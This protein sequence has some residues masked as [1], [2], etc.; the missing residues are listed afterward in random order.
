MKNLYQFKNPCFK[1]II[2]DI[3]PVFSPIS[4][5][6]F[7]NKRHFLSL[8]AG[9]EVFTFVSHSSIQLTLLSMTN[10][11]KSFPLRPLAA[12]LTGI[13]SL[14][15]G[16]VGSLDLRAQGWEVYF[17]G[18]KEDFGHALVQAQ[19]RGFAIA[20]FSESFGADGDMDVY[21]VRTDVDG[22]EIWSQVY[23]EGFV[24]HGY[25][26][27][28]T[29]DKGFLVVGDIRQSPLTEPNVYLLKID[30]HGQK[31]WSKQYG[32]AGNEVGFRVIQVVQGGGYLI[33]GS[34]VAPGG[35]PA[36]VLALRV[37]ESGNQAW[38]FTYGGSGADFGRGAVEMPDGFLL[39][40]TAVNP[41]NGTP[42]VYLLKIGLDGQQVWE[43]HFGSSDDIDEGYDLV[44]TQDG[45]LVIAGYTQSLSDVLLL[46][47]NPDGDLLWLKA[48]GGPLGDQA[49]DLLENSDGELVLTGITEIDVTNSDAFLAKYDVNGDELWTQTIGRGSHVDLGQALV[50][51]SDGGYVVAGYNSLFGTF[52]NDL[53]LIKAGPNGSVY[54]NH[55]QGKVFI[56][57]GDC[58]LQNGEAG[59][60]SWIVRASSASKTFFG[61]TD[62]DGNFD[63]TVDTGSYTM[64][65][66][67]R[68]GLWSACIA[69]Y[70]IAL[71]EQYDTLVR[72][73]PIL[74]NY[75]CPL[76][77][78]DVSTAVVQN[79]SN[80]GYVVSYCNA[81]TAGAIDPEVHLVLDPS[82]TFTGA[83]LPLA[84]QDDSLLVFEIPDLAVGECGEFSFTAASDCAGL[85]GEAYAVDAHIYP[86]SICLP[87]SP[88]WDFSSVKV[89]GY[90]SA[91]TVVFTIR[92]EGQGDMSAPLDFIV[93]EDQILGLQGAFILN[94]GKDTTI[95]IASAEGKTLRLLAEQ[96]PGHPGE[97]YPTV[98]IEG[99]TTSGAFS[100][101]FV[102]QF[103]EDEGDPFSAVDVQESN[104]D[105]PLSVVLRA[106]PKG[107]LQQGQQLIPANTDIGYH[108]YFRNTGTDTLGR[109]VIR[110][111]VSSLLDIATVVAGAGSHD[112]LMEVYSFGV[113]KFTFEALNLAPDQVGFVKFRISQKP[114]NPQG[115]EIRNSAAAF[116]GY[117]APL[118]TEPYVHVVGG[119]TLTDFLAITGLTQPE[120]A[121]VRVVAYPNPFATAIDFE[122]GGQPSGV[123]ALELYDLRGALLRRE[124][125]VGD[126]LRLW[127]GDLSPGMYVYR[128]TAGG[129]LVDTGKI[130][131]R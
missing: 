61:T 46:K 30:R 21:V 18:N 4:I 35:G 66:L 40:G 9:K 111:T 56:D 45:N 79:C 130:I 10:N 113:L 60:G 75:S 53:T 108:I 126:R 27:L 106:S 11:K 67:V 95:V 112:Y 128:L 16:L 91:E 85:P 15:M 22:T 70:N 34:S 121:G 107:Y 98:A 24:E 59:L 105:L 74:V 52:I 83:T 20:G 129:R 120:T 50:Q 29:A 71:N 6:V 82:L 26:I 94:S 2:K 92:N 62:G 103:H 13:L 78:V 109:L 33:V 86:D 131:V 119:T 80:I 72:N 39:T 42:D 7:F 81:G 104:P 123:L 89:N 14:W 76:L 37:D 58:V 115:A 69:A 3:L 116:L 38:L 101:G 110:D 99:C 5:L 12:Q 114:N 51:A 84:L 28:E 68:N 73:F 97:S 48:H 77:E 49:F 57:G 117:E 127:R 90:C 1:S 8:I 124:F 125:G 32:G 96:S 31:E 47:V 54:T 36:D 25:G 43:K 65:V 41:T 93:I 17:G 87:A 55:L 23:D 100:T 44:Q 118:Q 122:L 63:L 102:T 64:S 19:D 88:G